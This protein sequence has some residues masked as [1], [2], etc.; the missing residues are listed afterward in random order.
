MRAAARIPWGRTALVVQALVGLAFLGFL[1]QL[2]GYVPGPGYEY[3]LAVR[4]PLGL[5]GDFEHPVTLRGVSVGKVTGV[6]H[7]SGH[8]VAEFVVR[9]PT[10]AELLRSDAS[11]TIAYR[12]AFANLAVDIDP[13]R[14][15]THL[16]EG[17]RIPEQQSSGPVA[18][19]QVVRTLDTGTRAQLAVLLGELR[20]GTEETTTP[21]RRALVELGRASEPAA[22]VADALADRRN[23]LSR[24]VSELDQVYTSLGWRRD[25][26]T[27]AVQAGG[28]TLAVTG[29]RDAE[30]ATALRRLPS[31]LR[32]LDG[33]LAE[34]EVL[35]SPLEPALVRLRPA[36]RALR[37]ALVALREAVPEA[38]GLVRDIEPLVPEA[39]RPL[40]RLTRTSE[41]L[42]PASAG[43]TPSAR[44]LRRLLAP[45]AARR[46]GFIPL[47]ENLSGALSTNDRNGPL[48]R[49]IQFFE[50]F[51]PAAFGA[52]GARGERLAR[53]RSRVAGVL[54]DR[55]AQGD[56][57]ACLLPALV[58]GLGAGPVGASAP[59][60]LRSPSELGEG[61]A[62]R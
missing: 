46:A 33:A 37:P 49:S 25:A 47:S 7:E 41:A 16:V 58:P 44:D 35:A 4:S 54:L 9:D 26:L 24:L 5:N 22:G 56:T 62:R 10:A 21:L 38:R 23:L 42:G 1:L 57:Q 3:E 29:R 45:V 8:A 30:L 32:A 40:A 55:C 36:A 52:P 28:R 12:S 19:D 11:A 61:V 14:A 60:R 43:L 17:E 27:A 51:D 15:S 13:G 20:L 2:K 48:L 18:P 59:P 39:R 6:R 34:V 31:T 50:P 53:L